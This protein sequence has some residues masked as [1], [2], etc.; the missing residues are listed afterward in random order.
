M[1]LQWELSEYYSGASWDA[2]KR[3]PSA[4][5]AACVAGSNGMAK[6][7]P[8]Q[9]CGPAGLC[10]ESNRVPAKGYENEM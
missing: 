1:R 9:S 8:L 2:R 7:M 6:A 5:K 10:G 4:A 3:L